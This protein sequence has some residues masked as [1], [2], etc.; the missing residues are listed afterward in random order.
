MTTNRRN[1]KAA[2]LAGGVSAAIVLGGLAAAVPSADAATAHVYGTMHDAGGL[3]WRSSPSYSSPVQRPGFGV[4]PTTRIKLLCWHWGGIVPD[5]SDKMWVQASH[6]S[7]PGYG[8][9]YINEHYVNDHEPIN[10]HIPGLPECGVKPP[11]SA[12][13]AATW[14]KSKLGTNL[15][16]GACLA[17]TF[18]AWK[19]A[20]VNLWSGYVTVPINSGTY[21]I[22]IWGHFKKGITGHST[23]PPVGAMVFYSSPLGRTYSHVTLSIGGGQEVST[24]DTYRSGVHTETIAQH[25]HASG[26]HY[27]G[28]WLP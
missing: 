24:T 5:S 7:G 12:Q 18:A 20:G 25:D 11:S 28:W 10:H 17:F 2:A 13:K 22:D 15:D 26:G 4:Y 8:S 16:S 21:P 27:L 19:A 23:T 3:Y 1:G 14:A 9:G 6:Y